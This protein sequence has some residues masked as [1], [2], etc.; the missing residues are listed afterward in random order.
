M[1]APIGLLGEIRERRTRWNAA[2]LLAHAF[3]EQRWAVPGL[4]A[5]G[6]NLLV[7]PPKLG[8]SWFALDLAVAIAC[9]GLAF[10][11]VDVIE[12]D[13]LYLALE[14]PARRLRDRLLMMLAGSEASTRLDLET[15]CDAIVE[16]DEIIR[17]WLDEHPDARCVV[18]DVW[19]RVRGFSDSRANA[20]EADYLAAARMKTIADDYG[21]TIIV[22]H[23]TRKSGADDWVDTVS[24]T[25]GLA[26]APTRSSSCHEL[27][28]A[29]TRY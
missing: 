22:V 10:G 12:G 20:Y 23:H 3:P 5:E 1:P 11:Q 27:E 16:A 18:V 6:L 19:A 17:Q 9:G 13:V 28:A 29:P 26:D 24:G 7:G 8:K 14:D 25:N 4:I 2:E 15:S 21:V